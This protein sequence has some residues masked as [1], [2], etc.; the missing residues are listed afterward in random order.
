MGVVRIACLGPAKHRPGVDPRDAGPDPREVAL[1]LDR[2]S[3]T[4]GRPRRR[5]VER[6]IAN[7][8]KTDD[9]DISPFQSRGQS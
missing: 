6:E 2:L 5:L 1:L 8:V 7:K 9:E 3:R 4:G